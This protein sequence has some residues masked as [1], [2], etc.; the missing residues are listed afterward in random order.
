MRNFFIVGGSGP[1]GLNLINQILIYNQECNIYSTYNNREIS[2]KHE[3]V[4]SL[5]LDF[6]NERD[7]DFL[8]NLVKSK[9]QPTIFFLAS[10]S[11][12]DDAERNPQKS[13]FINTVLPEI[14]LQK[15]DKERVKFF[16]SSTDMVY[17]ETVDGKVF[18]ENSDK[19]CMNEYSKQKSEAEEIVLKYGGNVL[20]HTF[21]FGPSLSN[22]KSFYEFI[23]ESLL[24]KK[25]VSLFYDS[26]RNFID[27]KTTAKLMVE[28][29]EL[30]LHSQ[31]INIC[32]DKK[33]SKYDLGYLVA[34]KF[35]LDSRLLKKILFQS[36]SNKVYGVPRPSTTLM[37]NNKLKTILK[38]P[39][40]EMDL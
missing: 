31:I 4:K 18:D 15:L 35:N 16:F 1:L 24:N 10:I 25:E 21:M 30:D 34:K 36:Q 23:Y 14:F 11:K 28:L 27:F 32:S 9:D 26:Y 3:N 38:I 37:S 17:G 6:F 39:S 8:V 29:S 19:S 13:R 12:P 33:L 5:K 40:I 20:R 22:E 7:V 2:I